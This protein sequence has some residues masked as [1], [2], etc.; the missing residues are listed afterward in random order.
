MQFNL[1]EV[2]LLDFYSFLTIF[3]FGFIP[4]IIGKL[5]FPRNLNESMIIELFRELEFKKQITSI[6]FY[7]K[8]V[9]EY[10]FELICKKLSE[11]KTIKFFRFD[12]HSYYKPKIFDSFCSMLENNK[13]I[14]TLNLSRDLKTYRNEN[15]PSSIFQN[16]FNSLKKNKQITTIYLENCSLAKQEMLC[17]SD[18]L[19][20]QASI[21]NLHLSKNKSMGKDGISSLSS[22][23]SYN[24]NL[25]KLILSDCGIDNQMLSILSTFLS[26]NKSI[27]F[28][29]L[30]NNLISDKSIPALFENLQF[31]KTL[32]EL[33]LNNNSITDSGAKFISQ[34][35]KEN[36]IL[37][38]LNLDH[39][40]ITDVG[41]LGLLGSLEYNSSISTL[42]I[43]SNNCSV[44][45]SN[46]IY[47]HLCQNSQF[48][49]IENN[50]TFPPIFRFCLL[51]FL[52]SVKRKGVKIPKYV[53]FSIFSNLQRN[54]F[55][56]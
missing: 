33:K 56:K 5:D 15:L 17:L 25:N 29:D 18:Y 37:D 46:K 16:L 36:H 8:E 26:K 30:S 22:S 21:K 10:E 42:W 4:K 6:L 31:N 20:N 40:Q 52:C 23:L 48:W 9:K 55:H 2:N 28:I 35:L 38:Y 47:N 1:K 3:H 51:V 50:P 44:N 32:K 53:L 14:T 49:K 43:N 19:N 11:N 7:D 39:N 13:T 34:F 45:V 54:S 41:A 24:N 12:L 27:S